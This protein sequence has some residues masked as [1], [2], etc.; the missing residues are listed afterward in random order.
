M[1]TLA[2]A[3]GIGAAFVSLVR[4]DEESIL[5]KLDKVKDEDD[6][7]NFAIDTAWHF[8]KSPIDK[9]LGTV[10][11]VD[12]V[13]YQAELDIRS[14]YRNV[15]TPLFGVM[16]NVSMG[17]VAMKDMLS[18]AVKGKS[19]DLSDVQR[20]ALLT[21]AGY[22]VGGA[23]T[24]AMWK[25]ME[26]LQ[27]RTA[28]KVERA[29]TDEIKDLHKEINSFIDVYKDDPEAQ[30]FIEDLKEYQ[31]TLPQFD[32]DVKNIIPENTQEVIK[33]L[34][35]KGKW[36][37]Y[38]SDTGAA[39]IY[40]F[41]EERWNEISTLN[42]DLG[43]TENGRVSKSPEQQEK[44]MNWVIQDNT[45]GLMTYEIPVTQE[46]LLGAHKFG[47]DNFVK[48]YNADSDSKL[49][50]VLGEDAD[51]ALFKNFKTVKSI[52]SYLSKQVNDTK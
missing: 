4:N 25:G 15:S 34:S 7:A 9:T 48:I 30:L 41:T 38:D 47:F 19:A 51:N 45:R 27:S 52:K 2:L 6:I 10:P 28:R 17:V 32:N 24:N 11:G 35:S 13:K 50:K 43:L 29:I 12:L 31:Q 36:D 37:A 39:G 26:A 3:T 42:P 44:A 18:M 16:S 49:N 5:K 14:D 22:I 40:Q 8:I 20:K 1:L 21:N 33:Q 23:P 46:N